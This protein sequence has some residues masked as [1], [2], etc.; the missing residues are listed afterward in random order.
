LRDTDQAVGALRTASDRYDAT[1]FRLEG[2]YGENWRGRQICRAEHEAAYDALT[3]AEQAHYRKFADPL[4][5]ACIALLSTSAPD[6]EAVKVKLA[7]LAQDIFTASEMGRPGYEI[8]A[9]D[10]ERL[11]GI[12]A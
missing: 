8:V 5:S 3:D 4:D 6:M 12:V 10:V 11:T 9:S 2:S 7:L 1:K